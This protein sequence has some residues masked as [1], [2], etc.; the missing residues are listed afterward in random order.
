[1]ES[2]YG[3]KD[4]PRPAS[5]DLE[6]YKD[7]LSRLPK[8]FSIYVRGATAYHAG[9]WDGAIAEFSSVLELPAEQRK[10]RSTWAAFML[11][12]CWMQKDPK[13]A[14]PFFE[15]VRALAAE[16]FR[17]SLNLAADSVG[18]QRRLLLLLGDYVGAIR[19]YA[20]DPVDGCLSLRIVCREALEQKPVD[21]AL[22][23]DELSRRIVTAWVLSH[24]RTTSATEAWLAALEAFQPQ[25]P[26]A[27]AEYLAWVNYNGGKM[28]AA[29]RWLAQSD[30]NSPYALWVQAKLLQ[31]EGKLAESAEVFKRLTGTMPVDSVWQV[32]DFSIDDIWATTPAQFEA[33]KDLMTTLLAVGDYAG[34]LDAA[35][36]AEDW[37]DQIGIAESVLTIDKLR[38]FVDARPNDP[39]FSVARRCLARRYARQGRW[40][41]AL[42]YFEPRQYDSQDI[43]ELAIKAKAHFDGAMDSRQPARSR[44]E[45]SFE[46]GR[47]IREEGPDLICPG[48]PWSAY[49]P[50]GL[51]S[52]ERRSDL[53]ARSQ[54]A[55]RDYPE[56]NYFVKVAA[57]HMWQAAQLLPDNDPFCAH[58]L[59]L[60]GRY[61]KAK[62][63]E[64]ADRFY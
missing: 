36:K 47:I 21:P 38:A 49:L 50:E 26:V 40:A 46:L 53:E 37:I 34:A 30:P 55:F 19:E 41:E 13:Q 17:D 6:P 2:P 43:R 29:A 39:A 32:H 15:R 63:P 62:H 27:G 1:M 18:W 23:Q 44:A 16:G 3:D 58:A 12:K 54:D 20:K 22:V 35:I 9:E 64:D 51:G 42:P 8:E 24:P 61:L 28:D 56:M 45:H 4:S 11:G 14:G 57:E 33:N 52:P 25:E 7:L 5:L 10:F 31:R 59:Y 60:G 48:D